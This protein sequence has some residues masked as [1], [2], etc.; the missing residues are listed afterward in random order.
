MLSAVGAIQQGKYQEA[1]ANAQAKAEERRAQEEQAS[2]QREAI[3]RN[4]ETKYVLSRQL[5]LSAASGGGAADSTVLNLMA[6]TG[7][8]GQ[9]QGQSAIYEGVT[10]GQGL[11]Y[12]AAI[13]RMSGRAA[14]QAGY[15]NAATSILGGIADFAKYKYG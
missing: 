4:K 6:T 13:D 3:R 9:Y 5:A 2:A 7:A 12:Q 10:R 11:T 8:E 15:I 1:A 14:K